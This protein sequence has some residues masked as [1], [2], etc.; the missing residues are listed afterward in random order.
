MEFALLLP[1]FLFLVLGIVESG[2]AMTH[3]LA[4]QNAAREGAR[5]AATGDI[6]SAVTQRVINSAPAGTLSSSNVTLEK[7]TS[8]TGAWSA[9]GD[10]Q[11]QN[12]AA[13]GDYVRVT[14][15]LQHQWITSLFSTTPTTLHSAV[16][17]RRE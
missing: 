7:S 2:L 14:V 12:N 6:T 17:A 4:I 13:T 15:S 5:D 11:G 16:V 10:S 9:L 8:G 3:Y 1:V